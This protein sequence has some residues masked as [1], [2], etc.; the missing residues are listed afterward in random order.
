MYHLTV[1]VFY[2][3]MYLVGL[4][5]LIHP[6]W[7]HHFEHLYDMPLSRLPS[8]FVKLRGVC[9]LFSIIVYS[10]VSKESLY[11]HY[12]RHLQV[13]AQSVYL[14]FYN[15]PSRGRDRVKPPRS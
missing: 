3:T 10:A 2:S 14:N 7:L 5:L 15:Q 12:C 11:M 4:P 8:V 13:P 1:C 9:V 6:N